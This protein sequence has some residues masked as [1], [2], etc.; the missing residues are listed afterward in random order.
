[1]ST[2]IEYLERAK[3]AEVADELR[4]QG[5]T[6]AVE[7]GDGFDLLATKAGR[8]VALVVKAQSELGKV[9]ANLQSLRRQA[10]EQRYDEFRLVVVSPPH[11][12]KVEV[13]GLKRQVLDRL[14]DDPGADLKSLASEVRIEDVPFVEFDSVE[15]KPAEIR[16]TGTGVVEVELQEQPGEGQD[17]FLCETD[18]PFHFDIVLNPDL[19]VLRVNELTVD[20]SSWDG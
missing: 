17:E 13:A 15:V 14:K 3:T 6:V 7:P 11:A 16:L 20:T 5:Y 4:A 12:I 9:A 10:R 1:V 19:R 2:A 18:F 8:K